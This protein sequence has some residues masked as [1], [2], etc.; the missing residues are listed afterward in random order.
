[1]NNHELM[2]DEHAASRQRTAFLIR[3]T[4]MEGNTIRSQAKHERRTISG[5]VLAVLDRS[6]AVDGPL[7]AGL[8]R[9]KVFERDF[10]RRATRTFGTRTALLI[11]CSILEADQIRNAARRR[12][13][14]I[15]S[16]AMHCLRQAWNIGQTL[17]VPQAVASQPE[18]GSFV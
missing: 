6:I 8:T 14:S 15:S 16:F 17:S 11:R 7:A 3:C 12:E 2:N 9:F 5:Y 18:K 10:D 1:M 4:E 13:M